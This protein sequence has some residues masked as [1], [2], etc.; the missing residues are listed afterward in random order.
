MALEV[1]AT[2]LASD[3]SLQLYLRMEDNWNDTTANAYNMTSSGSPTFVSGQF[4]KGGSF[5]SSSSQYIYRSAAS[6]SNAMIS[7]SQSWM[8]WVKYAS[9]SANNYLMGR[10]N[11][12]NWFMFGGSGGEL[13]WYS[14]LSINHSITIPSTGVFHHV[15]FSYNST[16]GRISSFLNGIEVQNQVSV[17]GSVSGAGTNF[18]IG[19]IGDYAGYGTF[20]IDEVAMFSREITANDISKIFPPTNGSPIFFGNTAIA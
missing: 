8:F 1:A 12:G 2:T 14:G 6:M 3:S 16:T 19:R 18:A 13:T 9:F 17:T 10:S 7:T 4:G 5:A 11:G 20:S 15:C